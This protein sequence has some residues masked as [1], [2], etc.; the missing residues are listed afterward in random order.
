M[1]T[2]EIGIDLGTTNSEIATNVGGEIQIVKNYLG[3]DYTPSVVGINK[4]KTLIVG[5]KAYEA[6]NKFATD[7]E[8]ANNKSEIKRLMGTDKKTHF[9][10]IQKDF[11]P[12]EISSEILKGLKADVVAKDSN[13]NTQGV[14]I[15]VPAYFSTVQAEATKRAGLLAGFKHVVLLQEPI[16]AAISYGFS[17]KLNENWLVYDF[18]GG[19]FD[20]ALISSKDGDLKVLEHNG[21]NFLGGKDIDLAIID[22]LIVPF[23]EKKY[24]LKDFNRGNQEYTSI[25]QR[26][27]YS[28]EQAKI[29]LS[30]SDKADIELDL[31]KLNIF[32]NFVITQDDLKNVVSPIIQKTILLC[33]KVI[34]DSKIDIKNINR[35]ILIGGP[36]QLPCIREQLEELKIKID[37]SSDPLT[38]V[39]RGAALFASGQQIEEDDD[40]YIDENTY[41]INLDYEALSSEDEELVV[42]EIP[43]LTKTTDDYFIQVQNSTNTFNSNRIKL[44]NGKFK[45]Y[46]PLEEHKLNAFWIYLLNSKGEPLKLSQDSF[47]VT[48]GLSIAG[49]PLPKSI[50][51]AFYDVDLLTGEEQNKHEVIFEKNSILPLEHTVYCQTAKTLKKGEKQGT[52]GIYVYEG[53]SL[54]VDRNI[55]ICSLEVNGT[56]ITENIVAGSQVDIK[57][58]ID[59]SRTLDVKAYFPDLDQ[60]FNVRSSIYD[61]SVSIGQLQREIEEAKE[62]LKEVQSNCSLDE[63]DQIENDIREIETGIK[64]ASINEDE[65]AKIYN[66]IK[67]I[68]LDIDSVKE[69]N[70]YAEL[71]NTFETESNGL[72]ELPLTDEDKELMDDLM[73]KGKEAQQ[74][75]NAKK[76]SLVNEQLSCLK[77]KVLFH[78]KEFLMGLAAELYQNP[79]LKENEIAQQYFETLITASKD[80]DVDEMNNCIR[81]LFQL[82]PRQEQIQSEKRLSGIKKL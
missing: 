37:T 34:T 52:L 5:K 2:I 17:N 28:V 68:K 10:R 22:K 74:E 80:D 60:E 77:Y 39:A 53:E 11:T 56:E 50:G 19:T 31:D 9:S 4:G 8:L 76:L 66:R 6:L 15:T 63:L 72:K 26:I 67:T 62:E 27:K 58:T 61:P 23:L 75:Q 30:R 54:N 45:L 81:K 13:I 49:A 12:E 51:L 59:E 25:F 73:Q 65:K 46:V 71:N 33:Q 40:E 38:A 82:L 47:N 24:Q 78:N 64:V 36:T 29:Q 18:G 7:D 69:N 42:G 21:D 1:K 41:K 48:Q 70:S 14:V 3:D 79:S 44:Q 57:L 20:V 35:L 55:E 32:E 43:E 16:A